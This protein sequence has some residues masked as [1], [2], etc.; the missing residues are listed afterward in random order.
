MPPR[1]KPRQ[2]DTTTTVRPRTR[3]SRR[4]SGSDFLDREALVRSVRVLRCCCR[5]CTISRE[6]DVYSL[7]RK[8]SKFCLLFCANRPCDQ[9]L[10]FAKK[11]KT[12]KRKKKYSNLTRV[13]GPFLLASGNLRAQKKKQSLRGPSHPRP[14]SMPSKWLTLHGEAKSYCFTLSCVPESVFD[15][16]LYFHSGFLCFDLLWIKCNSQTLAWEQKHKGVAD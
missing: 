16:L 10:W 14:F 3:S 1:K 11:R 13:A 15:Y 5:C 12:K 4:I 6:N 7:W 2:T 8:H 9:I